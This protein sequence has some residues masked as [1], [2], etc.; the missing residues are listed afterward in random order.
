[1]YRKLMIQSAMV[2]VMA[3]LLAGQNCA[4]PA[5]GGGGGG[6]GNLIG[7]WD[8]RFID[9]TWGGVNVQ[10]ILQQD[11]SYSQ[12][13]IYDAGSQV[14]IYGGFQAL[15]GNLHLQPYG[16]VPSDYLGTP[17]SYP[18]ETHF[19]SFQDANTLVLTNTNC[20]P[21]ANLVCVVVY[22]REF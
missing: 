16:G 15:Q 4:P 12:Q 1:M 11:G 8:A 9:P 17:I 21:G 14:Y 3:G 2:L 7:V 6:G 18:S 20:P 10:L 19:F 13:T 5:G 22:Q